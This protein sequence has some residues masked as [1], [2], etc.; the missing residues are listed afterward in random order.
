MGELKL[1]PEEK[2]EPMTMKEISKMEQF[3][4]Q[5]EFNGVKLPDRES[6]SVE[7]QLLRRMRHTK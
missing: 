3:I 7:T 1:V 6:N 4:D 5:N 2:K